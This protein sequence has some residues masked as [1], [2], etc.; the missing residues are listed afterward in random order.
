MWNN[1]FIPSKNLERVL[2]FTCLILFFQITRNIN[3][4]IYIFILF[5]SY[6]LL[7]SIFL[8][9]YKGSIKENR[10]LINI[11]EFMFLVTLIY[12]PIISVF[13]LTGS[14]YFL[15]ISRY[16]ITLP[17]IIIFL[18]IKNFSQEF[19][20]R[21][22]KLFVIFM[23]FSSFSIIYQIQFGAIDFFA[24]KSMREG[25]TRYASLAGSLTAFGTLGNIAIL[26]LLFDNK[27][28]F[29][30]MIKNLF[31]ITIIAGL[32]LSLQKAAVIN[33]LLCMICY[34]IFNINISLLKKIIYL[35]FLAIIT[36][37]SYKLI[38]GSIYA[39]YVKG[40]IN[41]TKA[42]NKYGAE[43]D[44]LNRFWDYPMKVL[45]FNDISLFQLISGIG[46]KGMGGIMG[47]P[48]YPQ[49]HNNFFDLLYSGGIFHIIFFFSLILPLFITY[50][51][52]YIFYKKS[53]DFKILYLFILIIIIANMC[54]GAFSFYQPINGVLLFFILCT[55]KNLES[56]TNI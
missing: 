1:E 53:N 34:F 26:I 5:T 32:F 42:D 55:Y 13:N 38:E 47:M 25:V 4:Y 11:R 20:I 39:K 15:A 27:K 2:L 43:G 49:S 29:G 7:Y 45:E 12:I 30:V 21:F 51:I 6:F 50:L 9:E 37:I 56:R 8:T 17:I 22:L 46:F 3:L 31:L 33:L 10:I 36:S 14:E 48:M 54:I 40:I 28:L 18:I 24:E 41:F 19:I 23:V 16:L 52:N 44:L 35:I